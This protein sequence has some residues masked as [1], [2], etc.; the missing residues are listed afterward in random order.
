MVN[1]EKQLGRTGVTAVQLIKSFLH[2]IRKNFRAIRDA[3]NEI[4]FHVK[5]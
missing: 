5:I 3:F 4:D 1:F 2:S